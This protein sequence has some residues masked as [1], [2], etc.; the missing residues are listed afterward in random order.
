MPNQRVHEAAAAAVTSFRQYVGPSLDRAKVV[1]RRPSATRR[2]LPDFLIIGAQKCGTTSLRA[3]L[4]RHP[5]VRLAYNRE[6]HYFDSN[7]H[8]G[9]AWYRTHFP[10]NR[11]RARVVAER[12]EFLTGEKTP[13][14][15]ICPDA[16]ARVRQLLPDVKLVVLVRDP[17]ARALSQYHMRVRL[18][19]EARSFESAIEGELNGRGAT[20]HPSEQAGATSPQRPAY[21]ARGRYT[22]QLERWL[23][24]FDRD[25]IHVALSEEYFADTGR[26]LGEIQQFLGLRPVNLRMRPWISARYP[27]MSS[28]MRLR[29]QELFADDV[30]RLA[31][32]IGRDPGWW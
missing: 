14:Y 1:A 30:R 11:E 5:A 12:G 22:E 9:L 28:A 3:A 13:S 16:P 10:T 4:A 20:G 27:P 23:S 8:R 29:L 21:I 19:K 25:Q 17:L 24:R 32:I 18:G 2:V 6:V 31:G 15:L 7:Y 26:V